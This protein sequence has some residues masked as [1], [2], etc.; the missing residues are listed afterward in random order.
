M[1][2]Y[3]EGPNFDFVSH[4]GFHFDVPGQVLKELVSTRIQLMGAPYLQVPRGGENLHIVSDKDWVDWPS[5]EGGLTKRMNTLLKSGTALDSHQLGL[6]AYRGGGVT[7]RIEHLVGD[8]WW[9]EWLTPSI[10]DFDEWKRLTSGGPAAAVLFVENSRSNL[11]D[12]SNSPTW[13]IASG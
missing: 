10:E 2:D 9:V 7:V 1:S 6:V 8:Y 3:S 13:F 4:M 11:A 12:T 5:L